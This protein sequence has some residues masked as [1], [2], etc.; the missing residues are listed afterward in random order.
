KPGGAAEALDLAGLCRQPYK[1]LY[2]ASAR[3]Y[4]DAFAAQPQL[5]DDLRTLHRYHAAR[6]AA[7][8]AAGQG[9]DAGKLDDGERSRLRAQALAWLRADLAA[10]TRLTDQ[11]DRDARQ[12]VQ[13]RLAPWLG[14]ADLASVREP[15]ALQK[16]SPDE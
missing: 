9:Q 1:R 6:A 4:A 7:R 8:A 15:Q 10:C 2:H 12:T 5:A 16:L 13:R 11:G 14:D 3:L